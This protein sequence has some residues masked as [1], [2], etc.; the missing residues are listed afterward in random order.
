MRPNLITGKS[1]GTGIA[2]LLGAQT[3]VSP[4][5][6]AA[7]S[8]AELK[9]AAQLRPGSVTPA[10]EVIDEC[11]RCGQPDA[12]CRCDDAEPEEEITLKLPFPISTNAYWRST[13]NPKCVGEAVAVY[14][15]K[16]LKDAMRILLSGIFVIVSKKG[17][18]YQ[19]L[20]KS[21]VALRWHRPPIDYY[22]AMLIEVWAP[23]DQYGPEGRWFYDV[24][25]REK[26]L[27]DAMEKA[28]VMVNDRLVRDLRIVDR[29]IAPP[30]R[31]V[32]SIRRFR[33]YTSNGG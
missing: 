22:M 27:L 10:A 13:L 12:R 8:D 4:G 9:H 2:R 32:V 1:A 30:G 17:V 23:S 11:D 29:G 7:V 18:A 28:G 6:V 31:V 5:F 19:N 3:N 14:R 24:D 20:V 21:L 16:G 15:S 33:G 26:S 25:N